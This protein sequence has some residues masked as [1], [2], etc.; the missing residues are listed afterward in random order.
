MEPPTRCRGNQ[1]GGEET[2]EKCCLA[3]PHSHRKSP[4]KTILPSRPVHRP[5]KKVM[6]FEKISNLYL[7]AIGHPFCRGKEW[8]CGDDPITKVFLGKSWHSGG[9]TYVVHFSAILNSRL[10]LTGLATRKHFKDKTR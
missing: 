7:C 1:R 5:K 10:T 2:S 3:F 8:V 4:N 6:S 9:S